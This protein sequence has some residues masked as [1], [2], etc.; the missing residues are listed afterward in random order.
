MPNISQ[1]SV[2]RNLFQ[3]TLSRRPAS[4]GPPNST[5]APGPGPGIS[6]P[7]GPGQNNLTTNNSASASANTNGKNALLTR[8][9]QHRLK[10][11]STSTE[12]SRPIK[13]SE[14]REIV[15]RDKNGGYKLDVPALPAALIG[16]DGEEL[17]ELEVEEGG[18]SS[19]LD[20][21]LSG[22]DKEKFEAALVEMVIRHR[23]RQSS[24][25]PDE[26]LNIVHQSLRKKVAS[27]DGDNWMFEPERDTRF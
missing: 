17:G 16:E 20:A 27:L 7:P 10:P 14:N 8:P 6:I 18:E 24:G 22:R 1:S 15:V 13:I 3:Q 2:R 25:E 5:L 4:T 19:M 26:I 9:A 21:E 12:L 23:N 11:T